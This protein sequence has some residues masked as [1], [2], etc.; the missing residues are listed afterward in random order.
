MGC[1]AL[2]TV[3]KRPSAE[4]GRARAPGFLGTPAR[5]GFGFLPPPTAPRYVH[6]C[7]REENHL[8][9]W[10]KGT[11][12]KAGG[13][14]ALRVAA[15]CNSWRHGGE[16]Q[17][18]RAKQDFAR[19]ARAFDPRARPNVERDGAWL[20]RWCSSR[21]S[22]A[23]PP[24]RGRDLVFM[25]LTIDRNGTMGGERY[26]SRDDAFRALADNWTRLRQR[27][28]YWL[29]RCRCSVAERRE[30]FGTGRRKCKPGKC[31]H[32]LADRGIGSRWV[33]V[34]EQ[35]K[36]G[37]PHANVMAVCPQLATRARKDYRRRKQAGQTHRR[38]MLV[39]GDLRSH[40]V[41]SGFGAVSSVEA[42][43]SLD[44][45]S[46]YFVGLTDDPLDIDP[47]AG[48]LA[49][50]LQVP[51]EAP[52]GFRRL[53][54][55]VGFLPPRW[56]RGTHTGALVSAITHEILA[57][58]AMPGL[59]LDVERGVLYAEDDPALCPVVKAPRRRYVLKVRGPPVLE[60]IDGRERPRERAAWVA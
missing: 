35:H 10:P 24:W 11:T 21:R 49:K 42:V 17:R 32:R 50:M 34:V 39:D 26:A 43:K 55:G 8:L 36:S 18:R 16:C 53:R 51:T 20:G 25:V 3:A 48:E 30:R 38:S 46:G 31:P 5:D 37:W 33:M 12:P 4:A 27:I 2:P 29:V 6:A 57:S 28:D 56:K 41:A 59:V 15:R 54:C 60:R 58:P 1:P 22:A 23:I 7:H 19:V 14:H 13:E 40:V 9:L 44:A 47:T 45:L 52:H